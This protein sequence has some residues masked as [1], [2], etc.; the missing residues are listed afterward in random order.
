VVPEVVPASAAPV[1]PASAGSVEADTA[2]ALVADTPP[3]AP[4]STPASMD[5]AAQAA[6][7][8]ALESVGLPPFLA[9]MQRHKVNVQVTLGEGEGAP[10]A[11]VGTPV[12]VRILAGGAKV[13]EYT[14]RVG[15]GG[16]AVFEGIPSNPEVQGSI[17]YELWVDHQG[18]RFPFA[19]AGVP[20]DGAHVALSVLAVSEDLSQVILEHAFIEF[21][22]DEES[23]VV[24]HN[25]RLR[26]LGNTAVDLGKLP[27]GGLKLPCPDGGKHPSLHDE[28]D[29][30]VEV[31][32]TDMWFKGALLPGGAP[33]DVSVIYTVA[34]T[35]PTFEFSLAMPVPATV[36]MVIASKER[37]PGHQAAF[38]LSLL[39][40]GAFGDVEEV[41]NDGGRKFDVLRAEGVTLKA[42]EPLRFAV[43]GLPVPSHTKSWV[44]LF[45]VLAVAL[46]VVFGFRRT[47]DAKGARFSRSHL[48]AERDRLVRTLARMRKAHEK[49]RMPTVRFEREQEAIT[50]RLVSL[51]RALDRLDA[52]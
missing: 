42:G 18:V 38:P 10:V 9:A 33:A 26:N 46:L 49:G 12:G 19:L 40:R 36:G 22:P 52:R 4:A 24:R 34:Y 1:A 5:K 35:E 15:E 43:T 37:Q 27:G 8:A 50:A 13:K 44:V 23:L 45:G 16:L 3:A 21:F 2:A 41:T 47:G 30:L 39:T 48:T 14:A 7:A 51:Y 32:G 6:A 20:T 31:R 29:P 25:M 28:H 11:P 17:S